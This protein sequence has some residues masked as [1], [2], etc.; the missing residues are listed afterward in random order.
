MIINGLYNIYLKPNKWVRL[1]CFSAPSF[2]VF[3]NNKQRHAWESIWSK[4]ETFE[5]KKKIIERQFTFR[6]D[7][8]FLGKSGKR[9]KVKASFGRERDGRSGEGDGITDKRDA[10]VLPL[11]ISQRNSCISL[12]R[13]SHRSLVL[14]RH[15]WSS[16]PPTQCIVSPLTFSP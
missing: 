14:S 2:C 12:L 16:F 7:Q 6:E 5:N 1:W 13:C 8:N 10:C 4:P 11:R 15:P 3:V 9:V